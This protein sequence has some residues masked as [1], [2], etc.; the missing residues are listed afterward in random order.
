MA[1]T[2]HTPL[3]ADT[4]TEPAT[5]HQNPFTPPTP[6]DA[7][8]ALWATHGPYSGAARAC[9]RPGRLG[10][11]PPTPVWHAGRGLYARLAGLGSEGRRSAPGRSLLGLRA[12]ARRDTRWS[13]SPV[14]TREVGQ[15]AQLATP[16]SRGAHRL[17]GH[18]L[19]RPEGARAARSQIQSPEATAGAA[20]RG[21]LHAHSG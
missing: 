10:C 15:A 14:P 3:P 6:P 4:R 18:P 13:S 19:P 5:T 7:H 12:A 20:R 2:A 11:A 16:P 8:A 9:A 21:K 17:C 1:T